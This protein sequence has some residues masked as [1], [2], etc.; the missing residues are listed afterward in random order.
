M[1]LTI[2]CVSLVDVIMTI[3]YINLSHQLGVLIGGRQSCMHPR[4]SDIVLPS[5]AR[6]G[7]PQISGER[8]NDMLGGNG[9]A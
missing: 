8:H 5:G 9:T 3:G 2:N 6:R 4:Q 1:E 7:E